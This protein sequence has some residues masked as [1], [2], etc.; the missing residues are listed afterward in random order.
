MTENESIMWL[1]FTV[2]IINEY[3]TL[4]IYHP[5]PKILLFNSASNVIFME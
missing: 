3:T 1:L 4:Y 5:Q 2:K